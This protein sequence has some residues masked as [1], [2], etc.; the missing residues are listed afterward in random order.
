MK[1]IVP[2]IFP[3]MMKYV[4]TH[5]YLLILLLMIEDIIYKS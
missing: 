2:G 1:F 3:R 5:M 4:Y